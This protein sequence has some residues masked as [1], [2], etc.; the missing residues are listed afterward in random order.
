MLILIFVLNLFKLQSS[1]NSQKSKRRS[2]T[3]KIESK[4]KTNYKIDDLS[5]IA[6]NLLVN[7]TPIKRS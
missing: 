1:K 7:I 2:R 6:I 5:I 3:T 4:H